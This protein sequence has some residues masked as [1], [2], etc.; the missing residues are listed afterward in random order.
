MNKTL[1]VNL[2][3]GP[4]AGKTTLASRLFSEINIA[5]PFGESFWVQEYA[6]ELVLQKRYDLLADQAH[7]TTE[8]CRRIEVLAGNV[9]IIVTDSPVLLGLVYSSEEH[10][11]K[12]KE[13]IHS[14]SEKI[15]VESVNFFIERIGRNF[16]QRGRLGTV[17][18]A[19]Q[20]DN[21][22]KEMLKKTETPYHVVENQYDI[23]SVIAKISD[24]IVD[25]KRCFFPKKSPNVS[26]YFN[27][28]Q[29]PKR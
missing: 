29:G 9:D 6:K 8:Q 19:I 26:G 28:T 5:K 27:N 16:D 4:N 14:L 25:K 22:I 13:I 12:T 10:L 20:K 21:E 23:V 18:D 15:D 1:I 24:K 11:E 3:A 2:F 17:D 7:V